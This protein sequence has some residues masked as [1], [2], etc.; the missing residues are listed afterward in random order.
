[1][2]SAITVIIAALAVVVSLYSLH[3]SRGSER[4]S[5]EHDTVT[6]YYDEFDELAQ[7]RMEYWQAS[8][9]LELP[10]NYALA[11]Q[12]LT[13]ALTPL[14]AAARNQMLLRERAI[15]TRIF[16]LFEQTCYYR[17][18]AEKQQDHDRVEF[19]DAVLTYF[20][21]RLLANPRLRWLWS[22]DGGNLCAYFEPSTIGVYCE[23]VIDAC[24]L[25]TGDG[26]NEVDPIGPYLTN[27]DGGLS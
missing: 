23:S 4:Q 20:T 15:A 11:K 12:Y 13:L 21:G 17:E 22:V 1:M 25:Q 9:L 16:S 26:V 10:E 2:D 3:V 27:P 7:L 5:R 8:H 6:S 19:L 24:E 14:T 18:Q